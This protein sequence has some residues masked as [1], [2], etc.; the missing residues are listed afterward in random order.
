MDN[1]LAKT[2]KTGLAATAVAGAA[3]AVYETKV[4]HFSYSKIDT[5][6]SGSAP[7]QL[8]DGCIALEGGSLRGLY[9]AGVLD[10][11]MAEGVNLQTTV[12]VSAGAMCGFNYVSGQIGRTARF[13]LSNRFNQRYVGVG[14]YVENQSPFGFKYVFEDETNVEKLDRERFMDPARRFVAVATNIETGPARLPRPRRGL[15][16]LWGDPRLSN[17]SRCVRAGGA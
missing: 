3:M 16:R 7:E 6:P 5:I 12:G 15:R 13:N 17:A 11:L 2:V 14:A 9:T 4:K 8:V 10:A 1:K